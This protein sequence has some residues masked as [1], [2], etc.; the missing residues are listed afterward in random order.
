MK[1]K[2]IYFLYRTLQIALTPLLG[3]YLLYRSVRNPAYFTSLGQRFGRLPRSYRQTAPGAIWLH[4]VS[5]GEVIAFR[6]LAQRLRDLFPQAPL[7][8]SAG[9]LAGFSIAREKLNAVDARIFYAPLDYVFAVRRVLRCLRPALILVAETEIWPN[10]FREARRSGCGLILLNGR[11]SEGAIGRYRSLRWFF[12]HALSAPDAIL[13]QSAAMRERYIATGAPAERVRVTGNLKYDFDAKAVTPSPEVERFLETLRP[14][15]VWIAA[16][17]MPPAEPGD[18]DEDDA[19]IA[20]FREMAPAFPSLLLILVPRKPE[21][22][23]SAAEKLQRAGIP[24]VRRS[25]LTADSTL[26]LPGVLLLDSMGELAGL[27]RYA[28]VVFMGGTLAQ[29]GG[30]NILEPAFFGRSV[31][32]GPHM[33]N[34]REIADDFRAR[35]AYVE[36]RAAGEL[37][38][39]VRSLLQDPQR[40]AALGAR[41]QVAAEA[42]RG[43]TERALEVIREVEGRSLPHF[44]PPL[45]ARLP[46]ALMSRLYGWA[47]AWKRARDLRQRRSLPIPVISVGNITAGGTGKTPIVL[48]L[49]EQM[50]RDG[51]RTG[52]LTRGYRRQSQ[53]NQLILEPGAQVPAT[54][55]GDEAQMFLRSGLAPLGIGADRFQ[56]GTLLAERFKLDAILLDDGFQHLRLERQLD[57]VLIDALEPFGQDA[58]LP[59]GRLREPLESLAR[60]DIFVIT[61]CESGRALEAI[62]RRLRL[63][64]DRAPIFHSTVVPECWVEHGS[65]RQLP[66]DDLRRVRAG[67]F[68]GLGNPQ[69]FWST[70]R[71][72]H[73]EPLHRRTFRDHHRYQPDEIRQLA[74]EF[75]AS[76]AE[77]A[78]TTEKDVINLCES[79]VD[80]M[81][82]LRLCWLKIRCRV[83]RE[84]DLLA[85]IERC[86]Q[87]TRGRRT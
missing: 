22:F 8:I 14:S 86:L 1:T 48:H 63:Y 87:T 21:R 30:H 83:E 33:E 75:A 53:E 13:V 32:C 7:F 45:A 35:D 10:L 34:F 78:V 49:A 82:P 70:L 11:I 36:I 19:V 31:I 44:P 69:S 17:T 54:S 66:L 40:A 51:H 85:A 55:T 84:A 71:S 74:H 67:A 77:V 72:L 46:L 59:L 38:G 4:A 43:A 23:A 80:L 29:R 28:Q 52:I 9:T 60:A 20:A 79:A 25:T 26:T 65:E 58:L 56:T 62:E 41:A 50:A 64:N 15:A 73:V 39:T 76:G 81:S 57:I 68:C 16:S 3:A 5:V 61:R 24:L 2:G 42:H 18:P 27:F 12:R 37:A 47:G 6:G